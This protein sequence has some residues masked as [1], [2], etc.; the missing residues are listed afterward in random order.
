MKRARAQHGIALIVLLALIGFLVIGVLLTVARSSAVDTEREMRTAQALAK[1]KEGLIAY[2][3]AVLPDTFA[4]RPGDLPCPDLHN[5]GQAE[6]QCGSAAQRIGRLPWKTLGLSDL[7]DAD[8]ERLWYA[9]STRFQ[10]KTVNQ[11]TAAGGPACL[12]G[13]RRGGRRPVGPALP[14]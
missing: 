3:V 12:R 7:R 9:L 5:D 14:G 6:L 4:K 13:A 1:A 8:G 10:R 11:C 2:A